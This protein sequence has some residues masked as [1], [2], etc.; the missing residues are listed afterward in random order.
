M[1]LVGIAAVL[2][3]VLGAV[4]LYGVLSYRVTKRSRDRCARLTTATH[5][6]RNE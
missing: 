5:A 3:L 2:A 6:E 4:G 1:L